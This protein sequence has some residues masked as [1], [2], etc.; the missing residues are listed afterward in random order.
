MATA[1]GVDVGL[2]VA[3]ERGVAVADAARVGGTVA[4]GVDV[5]AGP[6]AAA[7]RTVTPANAHTRNLIMRSFLR[8]RWTGR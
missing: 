2:A 1:T 5:A 6:Q 4:A 8:R 7:K 3:C